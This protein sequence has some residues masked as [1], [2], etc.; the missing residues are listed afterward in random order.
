MTASV[1]GHN[2][3]VK[4]QRQ[5]LEIF[6][7]VYQLHRFL[8]SI[9]FAHKFPNAHWIFFNFSS[10]AE[11]RLALF[12]LLGQIEPQCSFKVCSHKKR[13]VCSEMLLT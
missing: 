13:S 1:Y 8:L 12:L 3:E 6:C 4:F 11:H 9:W 10:E 5:E 2:F 7:Y